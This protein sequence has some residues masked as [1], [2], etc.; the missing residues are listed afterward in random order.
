MSSLILH[1][2]P[3]SPF[4]EKIR[5]ILGYKDLAW[6]SVLVPPIAPKPDLIPLTGGYRKTPVL[7]IGRDIYCDTALIARVLDRVHPKPALVPPRYKASC[8]A[9]AQLEQTLFFATIPTLFQPAG[10]KA[11][12]AEVGAEFLERFSKDRAALFTGGS[13]KR[14]GPEFGKTHFLPLMHALDQQLEATP[15]LLGDVPTLADFSS[16]HPV[17]FVLNN[18]GVASQL[19]AFKNLL[20][21]VAR[22]RALGHGH[23]TEFTAHEALDTALTTPSIQGFDGPMLEPEGV[24]LGQRVHV[25]ATDYGTDPVAGVL[26]HASV[27]EVAI[28]R[29]DERAG[30]IVVHFPRAGFSVTPAS[31]EV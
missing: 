27:F 18:A 1:H 5:A 22:M 4:S 29:I 8:A 2:Y 20:A 13:A 6:K 11:V 7:Q 23:M 15:F 25:Q 19:D 9:F 31:A 12:L 30:E 26:M 21:W 14:P 3:A 24:R 16:Y 10:I 17:W 28:K